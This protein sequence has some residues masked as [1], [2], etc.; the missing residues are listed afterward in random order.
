LIRPGESQQ[1]EQEI[2]PRYDPDCDRGGEFVWV[3]DL[4]RGEMTGTGEGQVFQ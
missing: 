3:A 2:N 1:G 4:I